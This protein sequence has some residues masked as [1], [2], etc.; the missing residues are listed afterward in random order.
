MSKRKAE[1]AADVAQ[2]FSQGAEQRERI[3]AGTIA[4]LHL[5]NFMSHAN[6]TADFCTGVNF[7]VGAN[8]S[9]KSAILAAI[10]VA[11]GISG[12]ATNRTEEGVKGLV[13]TGTNSSTITLRLTNKGAD[14]FRPEEYGHEIVLERTISA[15]V[16]LPARP[17]PAWGG[18][19]PPQLARPRFECPGA[20]TGH[21]PLP[22]RSLVRR[23]ACADATHPRH[24]G[25]AATR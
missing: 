10:C 22:A 17:Q 20:E 24:P 9:G 8:G 7:V 12:R 11:M 21:P 15:T 5:V 6:F 1:A 13:R 19:V 3:Q 4:H 2:F 25:R 23:G 18:A 14:A 16:R